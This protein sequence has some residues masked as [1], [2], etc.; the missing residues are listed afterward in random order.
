VGAL[1]FKKIG[2]IPALLMNDAGNEKSAELNLEKRTFVE[3][4]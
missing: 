3:S 4:R 2:K 1:T